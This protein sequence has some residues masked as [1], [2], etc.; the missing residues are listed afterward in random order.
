MG[1]TTNYLEVN[2]GLILTNSNRLN[3]WQTKNC[4]LKTIN[5]HNSKSYLQSPRYRAK[6][7]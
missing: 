4:S 1:H 2:H 5:N 6:L 7:F 3:S